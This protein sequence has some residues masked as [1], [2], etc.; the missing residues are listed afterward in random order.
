[1]ALRNSAWVEGNEAAKQGKQIS[2]NPY[3]AS[4]NP[5][6]YW[7]WENGW[8]WASGTTR[9]RAMHEAQRLAQVIRVAVITSTNQDSPLILEEPE[10]EDLFG[11]M[12][13]DDEDPNFEIRIK[14]KKMTR[15]EYESLPEFE[16]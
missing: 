12:S 8:C 1:M 11:I 2:S 6:S 5:V 10:I 7:A 15:G 9:S 16:G 14:Y 13:G 4:N 3:S